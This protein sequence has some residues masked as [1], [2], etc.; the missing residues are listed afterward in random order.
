MFED[1]KAFFRDLW[2]RFRS[3]RIKLSPFI[4]IMCF[5]LVMIPTVLAVYYAYF[6]EDTSQLTSNKVSVELYDSDGE[7]LAFEEASKAN[8][9]DSDLINAF[10]NMAVQ[11][12]SASSASAYEKHNFSFVLQSNELS[13]TYKCYFTDSYETSYIRNKRGVLYAVSQEYYDL[14]LNSE[15]SESV[16]P[17][18]TPPSLITGNGETVMPSDLSW[19]YKKQN[20]SSSLAKLC[21]TTDELR[22]YKIGG[23]IDIG[24]TTPPDKCKVE[25]VDPS[26]RVLYNGGLAE[27]PF[28][29][30]SS[31]T[32]LSAYVTATWDE[33]EDTEYFGEVSYHFSVSIGD[34]AEFLIS[35]YETVAGGF[36]VLSGTNIDNIS[37]I[38]FSAEPAENTGASPFEG[39]SPVFTR[40]GDYVRAILPIPFETPEGEYGF[41]VSFGAAKK[42]FS[43]SVSPASSGR[44]TVFKSSLEI[45]ELLSDDAAQSVASLV[46]SIGSQGAEL[47]LYRG[48]FSTPADSD[49][50]LEY[51]YGD[52]VTGVDNEG[53]FSSLGNAYRSNSGNDT[54]V[55]ALNIG[56]V[57]YTGHNELLGNY[58]AVEHG[59]GLR[60]WYC[61]L[62]SVNTEV[63]NILAKG[64]TVGQSGTTG[65]I[66]QSGVYIL[67]SVY[68]RLI[69]PSFV[70]DNE[71]KYQ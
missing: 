50:S 32:V 52:S 35:S 48:A 15:Y 16:Y 47:I 2:Q 53:L 43:I 69:D 10:Y 45:S 8:I 26:L 60:T 70:V 54:S 46:E 39:F 37:N 38:R 31:G 4:I 17:N 41:S 24:F 42:S 20:G 5:L 28:L 66:S 1:I 19:S 51:S 7:R 36:I 22:T 14:F 49:F 44:V 59:M 30:V 58:V 65:P 55:K 23:A 27:L 57:I 3:R 56:T 34:S 21:E 9:Q 61:H 13:D 18:A 64:D 11:K 6:Y 33:S 40:D 12:L 68:D 29:T 67:C 71:I 63:G 25:I 62:S